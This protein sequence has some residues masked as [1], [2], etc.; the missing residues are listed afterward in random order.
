LPLIVRL[1]G[2]YNLDF[3]PKVENPSLKAIFSTQQA[4]WAIL[5]A[6]LA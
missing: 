3:I 4:I 2:S 5:S 6:F 1:L